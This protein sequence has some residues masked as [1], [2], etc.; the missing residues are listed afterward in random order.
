[1]IFNFKQIP[2]DNSD[3]EINCQQNQNGKENEK[4][5][6]RLLKNKQSFCV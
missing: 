6:K 1:M 2:S 3:P 4:H 5:K